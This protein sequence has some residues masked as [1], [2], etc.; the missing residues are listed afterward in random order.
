MFIIV[1]INNDKNVKVSI[2][3]YI[4]YFVKRVTYICD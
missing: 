4:N 3:K 2:N 1:V